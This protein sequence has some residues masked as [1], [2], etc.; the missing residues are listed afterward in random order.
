MAI[1][2]GNENRRRGIVL[3]A[4]IAGFGIVFLIA[5][6]FVLQDGSPLNRIVKPAPAEGQI[7]I[8]GTAV[9]LPHKDTSGPQ[10]LE[11][12]YGIKDS[13][14]RYF[15]LKDSDSGYKNISGLPI[16]KHVKINGTFKKEPSALY[17]TDGTIEV[18]KV[19][20]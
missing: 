15:G 20:K 12:A 14:G 6:V 18:T 4:L 13:Q 3:L 2:S 9:C 5:W 11:C 8:E 10:T 7:Q 17:P 16:N 1:K 19:E